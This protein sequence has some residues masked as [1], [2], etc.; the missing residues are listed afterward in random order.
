MSRPR[1]VARREA[2]SGRSA[3]AAI[4]AEFVPVAARPA[5]SRNG[6]PIRIVPRSTRVAAITIRRH[7]AAEAGAIVEEAHP[8]L[9][10]AQECF[11]VLRA[12]DFA[13]SKAALLRS[14]RDQ[15]KPEVIWN[16]EASLTVSN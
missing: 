13:L 11:H 8:D 1:A 3:V 10:E 6:S 15:L 14:K 9:R 16:I 4:A 2:T 7:S 5:T 12:F